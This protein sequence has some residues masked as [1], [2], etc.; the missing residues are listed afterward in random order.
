MLGCE[1]WPPKRAVG[2]TMPQVIF[3]D[4]Y[5]QEFFF[6]LSILNIV[7]LSLYFDTGYYTWWSFIV[8]LSFLA[9]AAFNL[10]STQHALFC[11]FNSI[12]VCTGVLV[13]SV[14]RTGDNSD[15]LSE[16]AKQQGLLVYGLS[17]YA[18][19][20]LPVAR[21]GLLGQN[22]GCLR[23]PYPLTYPN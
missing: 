16:T 6:V 4:R 7:A 1:V 20:Y 14:M 12:F 11:A 2:Q 22:R 19:H 3:L 21:C 8:F 5:A 17:T 9:A 10:L 15:M 18:V 13:M 23:S